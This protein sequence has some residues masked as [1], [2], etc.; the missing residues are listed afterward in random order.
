MI[1]QFEGWG[2]QGANK[3]DSGGVFL[4]AALEL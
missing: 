2:S 3:K 1:S 4:V